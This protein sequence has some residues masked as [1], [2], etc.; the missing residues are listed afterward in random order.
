MNV[1]RM[2]VSFFFF[3]QLNEFEDINISNCTNIN[4]TELEAL[5]ARLVL[6]QTASSTYTILYELLEK[7]PS[8]PVHYCAWVNDR[9]LNTCNGTNPAHVDELNTHLCAIR[10]NTRRCHQFHLCSYWIMIIFTIVS[11]LFVVFIITY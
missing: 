3:V 2:K 4:I 7:V 11:I 9:I 1:L 5:H 10:S 6:Y 8:R